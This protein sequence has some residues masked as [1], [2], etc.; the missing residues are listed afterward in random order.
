M[1]ACVHVC[2]C[3]RERRTEYKKVQGKR[4]EKERGSAEE[5]IGWRD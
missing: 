3:L 2:V 4:R 5:E 1:R